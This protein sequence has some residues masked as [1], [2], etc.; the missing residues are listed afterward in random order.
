MAT[1][2]QI[3]ANRRNARKST[4]PRSAEAKKRTSRNA[5]QH[6]LATSYVA[7]PAEIALVD[8]LAQQIAGPRQ[9]RLALA[10]ARDAA[11]AQFE[12]ARIRRLKAEL[13]GRVTTFGAVNPPQIFP[14]WKDEWR[15]VLASLRNNNS[16]LP[17]PIPP[18]PSATMPVDDAERVAEAIR[19]AL[20]ELAKLERYEVRAVGRRSR[21]LCGLLKSE[22]LS[23]KQA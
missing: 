9:E 1:D 3:A 18:D 10:L 8:Q 22:G 15:Y 13:I 4:G 14:T 7:N 5:F 17:L 20:P 23:D 12:L 11:L 6:G 2:R 21:A 16:W 19:R